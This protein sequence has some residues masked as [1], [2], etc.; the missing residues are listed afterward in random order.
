MFKLLSSDT[1]M[2]TFFS[3]F[4]F[5]WVMFVIWKF[6]LFA[7]SCDMHFKRTTPGLNLFKTA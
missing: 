6:H 2:L 7:C 3:L 4:F 5:L 1:E